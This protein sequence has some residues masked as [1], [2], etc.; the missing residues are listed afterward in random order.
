M[1]LEDIRCWDFM[2]YIGDIIEVDGD[3]WVT[4]EE[5]IEILKEVNS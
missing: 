3:G 5:A 4:K 1:N 2:Y